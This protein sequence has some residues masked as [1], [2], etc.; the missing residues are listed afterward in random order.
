MGLNKKAT[1]DI[2]YLMRI[3]CIDLGDKTMGISISDE[4][5]WTA[6][7][8]ET[9]RRSSLKKDFEHILKLA[10]EYGVKEIIVGLPVNMDGTMGPRAEKVLNFVERLS[11]ETSIKVR[12]WDERLSTAAV[13]RTLIQGDVSRAGRRKVV[14]KL[15]ASYILQGYLDSR[16]KHEKA[17]DEKP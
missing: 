9:L 11:A 6:Q 1:G 17:L 8:L 3:M 16:K 12:T 10:D 13:T 14:D 7:P 4:L 5:G 15:A 2:F